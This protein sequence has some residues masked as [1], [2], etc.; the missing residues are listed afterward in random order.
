MPLHRRRGVGNINALRHSDT[1][2]PQEP[3]PA[4]LGAAVTATTEIYVNLSP[5]HVI[6][7]FNAK[8]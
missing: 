7:E 6:Q 1:G 5:E 4:A 2:P 3:L 8:W